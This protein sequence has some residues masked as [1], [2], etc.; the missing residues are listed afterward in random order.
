MGKEGWLV[1]ATT[2]IATRMAM[3]AASLPRS[4]RG[5]PDS[6]DAHLPPMPAHSTTSHA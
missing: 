3:P 2:L 1:V 4:S 5:A 6:S